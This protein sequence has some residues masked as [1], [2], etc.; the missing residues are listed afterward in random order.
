MDIIVSI[1]RTSRADDNLRRNFQRRHSTYFERERSS[2]PIASD[3]ALPILPRAPTLAPNQQVNSTAI[4]NNCAVNTETEIVRK[5]L[6]VIPTGSMIV[7]AAEDIGVLF[8]AGAPI[9]R[10]TESYREVEDFA[11]VC[12]CSL[13]LQDEAARWHTPTANGASTKLFATTTGNLIHDV[14][15]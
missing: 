7:F 14:P 9:V 12:D 11:R 15:C 1:D 8:L 6:E 3:E 2:R 5:A 10:G 13:S 4:S